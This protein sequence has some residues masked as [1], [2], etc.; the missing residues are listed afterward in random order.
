VPDAD[1]LRE[2]ARRLAEGRPAE[3][4]EIARRLCGVEGDGGDL[5]DW[6]LRGDIAHRLRLEDEAFASWLGAADR[7]AGAGR[8]GE[9]VRLSQ[10]I[11]ALDPDH[12]GARRMVE[13]C[14]DPA[15][16][17]R[18]RHGGGVVV[19]ETLDPITG[20]ILIIDDGPREEPIGE[21]AGRVATA[22]LD[23]LVAAL[24]AGG[25]IAPTPA[26]EL[27]TRLADLIS[28]SALL[29]AAGEAEIGALA[30]AGE[31]RELDAGDVL[32]S[33]IDA[34]TSLF[35][36]VDGAVAGERTHH[37]SGETV[38]LATMRAGAFVGERTVLLGGRRRVAARC[39]EASTVLEVPRQAIRRLAERRPAVKEVLVRY[40]RARLVGGM[41]AGSPLFAPLGLEDRRRLL[42]RFR[43]RELVA[44]ELV[45]AQGQRADGLYL[46]LDGELRAYVRGPE[47]HATLRPVGVLG[48]GDAFGQES[49]AGDEASPLTV[50]AESQAWVLKLPRAAAGDTWARFPAARD[51]LGR[52]ST[53]ADLLKRRR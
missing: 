53:A 6:E 9:A 29:G 47:V 27:V 51:Q 25:E 50:R 49:V 20:P 1:S 8:T 4:L 33:E 37:R 26:A 48:P 24:G 28:E 31:A 16:L 45:I 15:S 39:I 40:F 2:R 36:I 30:R 17:P 18:R 21:L 43:L 13:M 41:M 7:A 12:D 46:C 5:E 38:R 14:G 34:G 35:V 10:R 11:L 32:F 22:E 52:L 19:R 44:G 3:A 42:A 23:D